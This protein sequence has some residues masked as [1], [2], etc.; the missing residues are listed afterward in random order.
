MGTATPYRTSGTENL[1]QLSNVAI[2]GKTFTATAKAKSVTTYVISGV[3]YSPTGVTSVNDNT[4]GTANNQFAYTGTWLSGSQTGAY[5][6]DNHW[7]N[8]TNDS[9]TVNFSGTQALV[10]GAKNNN[11][12][13]AAYSIDGGAETEVDLYSATRS[14]NSFLFASP[15]LTKGQHT[16]K[17]RVSGRKNPSATAYVVPADRVDIV[18]G[19][20]NLLS[21]AGFETGALSP[22]VGDIN[23]SLV[24]VEG[25]Y[26]WEG[27]KDG[28]L[29]PT[30]TSSS[31]SVANLYCTYNWHIHLFSQYRGEQW[32][33]GFRWSRYKRGTDRQSPG[34]G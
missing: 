10:Y 9:Y 33:F 20:A 32:S 7:S 15:T 22:W 21:N 11:H 8:N 13:I 5:Q 34:D 28:S 25:N 14:D 2:S 18:A 30:S 26:P 3:T 6:N 27:N 1:A 16:L 24:K 4:T 23:A 12:G 17:V 31:K 19:S 29:H